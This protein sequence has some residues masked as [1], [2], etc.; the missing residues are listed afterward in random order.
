MKKKLLFTFACVMALMAGFVSCTNED[1]EEFAPVAEMQKSAMTRSAGGMTQEEVQA[2]LD[3]LGEKYG[4]NVKMLYVRDYSEFTESSFE[5]M[6]QSIIAFK[7][8]EFNATAVS[9]MA[10]DDNLLD[11]SVIDEYGIATLST[12]AESNT[13]SGFVLDC[14]VQYTVPFTYI[15]DSCLIDPV[16]GDTIKVQDYQTD[17]YSYRYTANIKHF[18]MSE[19]F[20]VES[21]IQDLSSGVNESGQEPKS[22]CVVNEPNYSNLNCNGPG[23]YSFNFEID[24]Y[25]YK[26]RDDYDFPET[27]LAT[28][29]RVQGRFDNGLQNVWAMAYDVDMSISLSY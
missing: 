3:E 14:N 1:F 17:C 25:A 22:K 15:V 2:R 9:A 10:V 26:I 28:Q 13:S 18:A 24:I 11:D 16:S 7:D 6:E 20:F 21:N 29:G 12:N 19:N 4:I 5:K 27:Y 8:R 23:L